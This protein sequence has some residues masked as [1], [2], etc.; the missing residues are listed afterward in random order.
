VDDRL[1]KARAL[2]CLARREYSR[3]ELRGKL[4]ALSRASNALESEPD[5]RG[6]EAVARVDAVLDWLE[7]QRYLSQQRF[8]ESRVRMRAERFGLR[9]IRQELAQHGLA[10]PAQSEAA[11]LQSEI[12][13]ARAV[14]ARK[15]A[16][17]TGAA[18]PAPPDPREAQKQA[19]FLAGR[20][21]SSNVVRCV[22]RDKCAPGTGSALETSTDE[23]TPRDTRA[24]L[25][26]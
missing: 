14:W 11:L 4:L 25:P 21:F 5:S 12:E 2:A 15:F 17:T 8:V 6:T 18:A 9:R 20:G 19:R 22:L 7:S 16:H 10:L 26:R 23:E 24:T 1:L 13:R 3:T